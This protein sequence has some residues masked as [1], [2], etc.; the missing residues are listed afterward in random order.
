MDAIRENYKTDEKCHWR[1]A[2]DGIIRDGGMISFA[3]PK[4]NSLQKTN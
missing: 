3:S 1:L 2:R 4:K